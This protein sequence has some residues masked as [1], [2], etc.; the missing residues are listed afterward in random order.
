MLYEIRKYQENLIAKLSCQFQLLGSNEMIE[1]DSNRE[2]L[3]DT[4]HSTVGGFSKWPD[5]HPGNAL[6][7][8]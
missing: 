7:V 4:Q 8:V 1:C 6:F 3:M 2:Y 5:F